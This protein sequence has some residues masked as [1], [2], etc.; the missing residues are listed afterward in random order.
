MDYCG[1]KGID[2]ESVIRMKH[3]YNQTRPYRHG[4]KLLRAKQRKEINPSILEHIK[5]SG[6]RGQPL[7]ASFGLSK[8][9][10]AIS[11]Q[12]HYSTFAA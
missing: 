8:P 3:E 11:T 10:K 6:Q 4:G 1:H 5:R 7:T 2:L 12:E 9:A